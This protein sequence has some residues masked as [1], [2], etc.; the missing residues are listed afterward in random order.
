MATK[1]QKKKAAPARAAEAPVSAKLPAPRFQFLIAIVLLVVG[2]CVLYPE[3]VFQDKVFLAG[4]V[5]AATSFATPIQE[6]MKQGDSYPLWNPYLYSGMPSYESLSFIPYVYPVGVITGF[7]SRYLGFPNLTWLL[8][9]IFMLG[10]GVYLLLREF[11]VPWLIAAAAGIFMMWMPNHVAVGAHGHGSQACAVAYMP[12]VLLFWDRLWRGKGVLLNASALVIILGLQFLRGHLQITYYTLALIGLYTLFFASLRIADAFRGRDIGAALFPFSRGG[13]AKRTSFLDGVGVLAVL[14]VV[15]AASL[16]V[17]A[18]LFL[19]VQ[20]FAHYS[21]RGASE[22]GGLD[23]DYATSWS[24]HPLETM[25]FIVPSAFGYGKH[26]YHGQMPFTDYPNYLGIVAV[27]FAVMAVVLV[28]TRF[29]SFLVFIFVVTTLV[30]FGRHLPLL[31]DPLFK[32]MPYFNKF[33]VPVMVLIVQQFTVAILFGIGLNAVLKLDAERGR[34]IAQWGAIAAG[35]ALVFV[36]LSNT[37][38]TG[39]YAEGIAKNIRMVRSPADQIAQ[40]KIAG[41]AVFTDLVRGSFLL[42][43][44]FVLILLLKRRMFGALPFVAIVAGLALTDLYIVDR[45]IIYPESRWRNDGMRIIHD[46]SVRDAFLQSDAAIDFLKRDTSYYRIFPMSHPSQ[47][48]Y[49]DFRSNRYMNFG[50]ASIGGYHPAKLSIYERFLDS[51]GNSLQYGFDLVNMLNVRYVLSGSEL[52]VGGA[53][54]PVWQGTNYKGERQFIYANDAAFERIYF[55]DQFEV[56]EGE[57]TAARLGAGG[58]LG[59]A[60][61]AFLEK[62]PPVAPVSAAGAEATIEH[63]GLGELRIKANLPSAALMVLSEIYYPRWLVTVNGEP[64]EVLKANYILRALALPAGT[65]DIVFKY[66]TSLLRKSLG[67]SVATIALAVLVLLVSS[68]LAWKGRTVGSPDRS[69]N[70]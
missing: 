22:S 64:A 51:L 63:Y 32:F 60:E 4:D 36:L 69:P 49:G 58:G 55:V 57:Q 62:Q 35:A 11:D 53:L 68:W 10:L 67:I 18:V 56:M 16:A 30:A 21:I 33:R 13:D 15:I 23:Y 38:W 48:L 50:I 41:G 24:L 14:G 59:L 26:T 39:A 7:M 8:F 54:R 31:Y 66:D 17:S 1:K 44:S 3:L 52:Q 47:A 19:P 37:Y 43:G 2:V 42:L 27:L 25:T 45:G 5:E 28:R 9:H 20:D 46:K 34:K 12:F 61:R 29:V 6:A 65:H 40:A 70:V